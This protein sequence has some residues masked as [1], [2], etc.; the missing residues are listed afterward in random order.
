M[1][2]HDEMNVSRISLRPATDGDESFLLSVYATTRSAEMAA[3]PWSAE[4]KEA[5]VRMQFAAQQQ[6]YAAEYPGAAHEII[7]FDAKPSG[8]IYMARLQTRL[9][10]LD[11]TVL[12][13][14]RNTGIGS[15]IV[16]KIL[17]EAQPAGKEVTI[18]VE[19]FSP[20][21]SFFE[22]MGFQP[23]GESGFHYLMKWSPH[24]TIAVTA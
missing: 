14:N 12:P 5:F 23:A 7:C 16:G 18:H 2:N 21:L 8:R 9:H 4:Q 20:S 24:D 3:V 22:R 1:T 13:E 17:A 6:H 10:I 11:I 15:W 19:S